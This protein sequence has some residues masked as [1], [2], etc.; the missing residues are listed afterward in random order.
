MRPTGA[1]RNQGPVLAKRLY[2]RPIRDVSAGRTGPA[3]PWSSIMTSHHPV[4]VKVGGSLFDWPGLG[5]RLKHWLRTLST[6]QILLV[7][8]GGP[9][10]DVVRNLD[11]CHGLGEEAAHWLALGALTLNAHFLATILAS[12][13]ATVVVDFQECRLAWAKNELPVLDPLPFARCD[14]EHPDHLPHHWSATSDSVAARA[15]VRI[16]AQKLI[17]LKSSAAPK[18]KEWANPE[19]G[20]VD[21]NFAKVISQA[22]TPGLQIAA[23]NFRDVPLQGLNQG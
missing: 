11:Q 23:L 3:L 14:E 15:A 12:L 17:L 16:E 9:T 21:S 10:A 4:V 13:N 22:R 19:L 18:G 1:I 20:F 5:P 6:G 2:R 7:P 8:G